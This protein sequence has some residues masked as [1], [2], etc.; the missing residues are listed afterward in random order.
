M[1]S[2]P[3][4]FAQILEG[5]GVAVE[6]LMKNIPHDKRHDDLRVFNLGYTNLPSFFLRSRAYSGYAAYIDRQIEPLFEDIVGSKKANLIERL[7][8]LKL[9]FLKS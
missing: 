7:I 5:P 1:L 4:Y 2:T 3:N 8:R 9:E 6:A